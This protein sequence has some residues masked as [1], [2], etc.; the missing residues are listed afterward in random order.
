[1]KSME[2]QSHEL[3]LARYKKLVWGRALRKALNFWG[4]WASVLGVAISLATYFIW[5]DIEALFS[6]LAFS[7]ALIFAILV[8]A[9]KEPAIIH[10]EQQFVIKNL[11][12][13]LEESQSNH[14]SENSIDIS[15]FVAEQLDCIEL[16]YVRGNEPIKIQSVK[17]S[18]TDRNGH[19]A[20][21]DIDKFFSGSDT[22]LSNRIN[23]SAIHN[24]DSFRFQSPETYQ[25]KKEI[26]ITLLFC[27]IVSKREIKLTKT[28]SLKPTEAWL[29]S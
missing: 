23:P 10:N 16:K 18:Y 6:A 21:V 29:T 25:D 12:N 24:G 3:S 26:N 7:I 17:V 14:I 5:N 13:K 15:H 27:G 4:S 20:Q 9:F 11:K 1:M 2:H 8:Y 19:L 22:S 28:V